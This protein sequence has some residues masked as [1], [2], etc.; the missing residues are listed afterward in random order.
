MKHVNYE[1]NT[2]KIYQRETSWQTE[3]NNPIKKK[4]RNSRKTEIEKQI[5]KKAKITSRR[6]KVRMGS[7]S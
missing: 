3:S 1:P 7:M 6:M 2:I 5:D 4:E